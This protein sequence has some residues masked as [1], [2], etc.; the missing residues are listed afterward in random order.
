MVASGSF[1]LANLRSKAGI[2]RFDYN[3]LVPFDFETYKEPHAAI[4]EE[5]IVVLCNGYSVS[6]AELTSLATKS[7]PNA[8]LV[9]MRTWGGLCGLDSDPACYSESYSGFFGVENKTAFYAYLPKFVTIHPELGILEG[10]GVTPD[11]E[12]P[13][14]Q[15]LFE[16]TGRDNQFERAVQLILN[17]N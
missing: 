4:T 2:G 8:H 1:S 6:M 13:F 10:I 14:D 17:G 12:I 9:G 16:S 3:P 5:P 7:L 15:S 11:V